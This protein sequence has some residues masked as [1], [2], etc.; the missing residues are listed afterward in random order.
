MPFTTATTYSLHTSVEAEEHLLKAFKEASGS[1]SR[2]NVEEFGEIVT[3]P[4]EQCGSKTIRTANSW[5]ATAVSWLLEEVFGWHD[6]PYLFVRN[7]HDGQTVFGRE[8]L[9][10]D[11]IRHQPNAPKRIANDTCTYPFRQ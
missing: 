8:D 6:L 5:P 9:T 4:A 10:P 1:Y 2:K 11:P 3:T 7:D